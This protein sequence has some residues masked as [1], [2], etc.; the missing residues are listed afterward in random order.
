MPLSNAYT[1]RICSQRHGREGQADYA[2]STRYFIS[3]GLLCPL[4]KGL[5]MGCQSLRR[6]LYLPLRSWAEIQH[7]YSPF[8]FGPVI[9]ALDVQGSAMAKLYVAYRRRQHLI[10]RI[11][12]L[13]TGPWMMFTGVFCQSRRMRYEAEREPFKSCF[14]PLGRPGWFLLKNHK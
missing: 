9:F 12:V 6:P 14:L 1:G 11:R 4:F 10:G 5:M 2:N 13:T 7:P 8:L 3:I